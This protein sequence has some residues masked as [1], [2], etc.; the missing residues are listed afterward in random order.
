MGSTKAT[1]LYFERGGK[2]NTDAALAIAK[3]RAD[4]LGLKDVIVA[5]YSGY[6]GAKTVKVFTGYNVTVVNGLQTDKMD[7]AHR[8]E[9]EGGQDPLIR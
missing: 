6:T 2:E 4:A 3:E 8:Q 1:T 7:R 9:I 5:S